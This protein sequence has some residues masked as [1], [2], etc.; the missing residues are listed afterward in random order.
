MKQND[1]YLLQALISTVLNCYE[2]AGRFNSQCA[3]LIQ[4]PGSRY[5]LRKEQFFLIKKYSHRDLLQ[6][7][8]LGNKKFNNY[9]F[10][11]NFDSN[12]IFRCVSLQR[13]SRY[14][15]AISM[16]FRSY[17]EGIEI[18]FDGND[19]LQRYKMYL[20]FICKS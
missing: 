20:F 9:Y 8:Q 2:K 12:P 10:F 11:L 1:G 16:L 14:K 6:L 4:Y 18:G 19:E 7:V 5:S 13:R 17:D 15:L 3:Y